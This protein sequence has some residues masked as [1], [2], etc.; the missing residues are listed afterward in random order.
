MIYEAKRTIYRYVLYLET[1]FLL[2]FA[3]KLYESLDF[4]SKEHYDK[5]S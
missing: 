5:S 1:R 4:L 3:W 2:P